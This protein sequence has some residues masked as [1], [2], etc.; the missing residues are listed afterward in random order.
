M[1]ALSPEDKELLRQLFG[2]TDPDPESAGVEPPPDEDPMR[3]YVRDLFTRA[4]QD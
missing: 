4:N 1:S 3:T 2:T